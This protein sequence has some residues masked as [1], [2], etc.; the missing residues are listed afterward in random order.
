MGISTRVRLFRRIECK[1]S[2]CR[3]CVYLFSEKRALYLFIFISLNNVFFFMLFVDRAWDHDSQRAESRERRPDAS[4]LRGQSQRVY[5]PRSLP[6][7]GIVYLLLALPVY[8]FLPRVREKNFATLSTF[9]TENTSMPGKTRR[10]ILDRCLVNYL[11]CQQILTTGAS[12][13][14]AVL[15]F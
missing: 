2:T 7:K 4:L 11:N 3:R 6:T 5:A 8:C 14:R 15:L 10:P 12:I 1:G 13:K 9:M